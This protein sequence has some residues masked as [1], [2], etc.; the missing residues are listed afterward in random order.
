LHVLAFNLSAQ[1]SWDSWV[2]ER[3]FRSISLPARNSPVDSLLSIALSRSP[4]AL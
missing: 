3:H 1:I 4:A 2:P